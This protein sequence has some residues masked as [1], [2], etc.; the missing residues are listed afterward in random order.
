MNQSNYIVEYW[1]KIQSGEIVACKRIIQQY[2]KLIDELENPRD[3][4]IYDLRKANQP[5]EFIE[6]FCKHSKR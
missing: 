1:N 4:W 2:K 3:P 5:I 6:R